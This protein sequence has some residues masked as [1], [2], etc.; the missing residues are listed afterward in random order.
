MNIYQKS[1]ES[2]D[3]LILADIKEML[4]DCFP[5]HD[6][7]DHFLLFSHKIESG[8]PNDEFDINPVGS[9][10]FYYYLFDNSLNPCNVYF[11][12]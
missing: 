7:V 1:K 12:E 3:I 11:F 10:S 2:T 6:Y 8:F 5:E 4:N 9:Y